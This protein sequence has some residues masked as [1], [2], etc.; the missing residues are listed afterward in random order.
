M[1]SLEQSET[2]VSLLALPDHL[3]KSLIALELEGVASADTVAKHTCRARA[4]ESGYLNSLV[5]MGL[6]EK[7]RDHRRVLFRLRQ[8]SGAQTLWKKLKRMPAEFRNIICEGMLTAFQ[9]RVDV[10][11][12]IKQN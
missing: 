5:L 11:T 2:L 12:R 10:F 3:R 9:N 8:R 7:Q 1:S 4:V 6:V